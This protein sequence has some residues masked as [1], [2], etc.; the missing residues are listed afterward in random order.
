MCTVTRTLHEAQMTR[1]E[2][3]LEWFMVEKY[4]AFAET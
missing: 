3:F 2:Y 4:S 1:H